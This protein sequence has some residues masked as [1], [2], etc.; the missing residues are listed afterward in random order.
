MAVGNVGDSLGPYTEGDT[1]ISSDA[2][3]TWSVAQENAHK[4]EFGDQGGILV[5]VDDEDKTDQVRYSY[6]FGKSW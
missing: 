5:L 6:D 4:Y 3:L 2:G 1:F